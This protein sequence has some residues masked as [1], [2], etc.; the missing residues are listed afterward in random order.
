MPVSNAD[1]GA[2]EGVPEV[3]ANEQDQDL[4]DNDVIESENSLEEESDNSP[5]TDHHTD[6][7]ETSEHEES[8]SEES[9]SELPL[10]PKRTVCP[11][12]VLSYD[13]G[14]KP[15]YKPVTR[16]KVEKIVGQVQTVQY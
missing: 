5:D 7:D 2:L 9:A 1:D 8:D 13:E 12:R 10:R 4:S 15:M 3:G 6:Q 11:K 16:G 14:G